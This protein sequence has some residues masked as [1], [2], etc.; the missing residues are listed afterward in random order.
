MFTCLGEGLGS[1]HAVLFLALSF[2]TCE[3]QHSTFKKK[4]NVSIVRQVNALT[5]PPL[6]K[7]VILVKWMD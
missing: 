6:F 3:L 4:I 5:V 2:K 7:T 1:R